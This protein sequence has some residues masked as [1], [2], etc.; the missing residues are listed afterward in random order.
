M[1][2]ET[3]QILLEQKFIFLNTIANVGMTWWVSSIVFCGS[4][5]GGIWLKKKEVVDMAHFGLLGF[6]LGV[7]FA[8]IVLFGI[9]M[10]FVTIELQTEIELLQEQLKVIGHRDHVGFLAMKFGYGLGATSFVLVLFIWAFMWRDLSIK[11]RL[12]KG[13]NPNKSLN[14]EV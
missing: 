3:L 14:S 9:L 12:T 7:F 5:L 6:F 13:T 4:V 2:M 1:S 11:H 8:S 10:I